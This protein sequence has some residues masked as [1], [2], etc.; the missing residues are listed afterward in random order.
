MPRCLRRS[1]RRSSASS[2]Q[3]AAAKASIETQIGQANSLLASLK[4]EIARM[5][6]ADAAR[7]R[8]LAAAAQQRLQVEH[9]VAQQQVADT[10]VG[11]TAARAGS[12]DGRRAAADARRGGRCRDVAAGH[13][14]PVGAARARRFR[15]LGARDVGVRAGRRLAA[16]LFLRA[17]RLR[18]PRLARPAAAG[19]PRLLRRARPR[20]HL[21]RRRAV[22]P[23]P[24]HR[25][26]GQDLEPRRRLVLVDATSAR[27]G[28][29]ESGS[30][31]ES[32]SS[33]YV[34][35]SSTSF[36]KW[37]ST[38]LRF[39]FNVGVISSCSSVNSRG[40]TRSA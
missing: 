40:S 7:Q 15:L 4:G 37:S 35:S 34:Y 18:R 30:R 17:V 1:A 3:R 38:T 20:R 23:R 11:V 27:A 9:R 10:V 5:V 12:R 32:D 22:R 2:Q 31:S 13:A 24:A 25:R 39:S 6:A 28:F 36:A 19:R 8:Q 33:L 21:H 16:A 26:R 29:S 14:V